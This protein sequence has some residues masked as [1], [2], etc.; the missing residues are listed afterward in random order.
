MLETEERPVKPAP[1][2]AYLE[3]LRKMNEA[4]AREEPQSP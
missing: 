1:Q 2:N 4:A 3:S